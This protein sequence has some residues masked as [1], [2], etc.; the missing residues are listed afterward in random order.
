MGVEVDVR[1]AVKYPPEAFISAAP[2]DLVAGDNK[3]AEYAGFDPYIL[4]IQGLSFNRAD[5]LVFHLDAD[6]YTDV[7]RL[8][9]L[10]S[11][12]GLDFEEAVKVPVVR[13][14]TM[15]IT[16]PASMS[17]YQ[18]RHRVV[19]FRPTVA[20]KLQLGLKL[21]SEEEELA[22]RYGVEELLKLKTPEPFNLYSGV[23]ELREVAVKL[24]ASGAVARLVVPKGKKLVLLGVSAT[25]PPSPGS[26]Y[27]RVF[28]DDVEV[29]SLD[30]YCLPSLSYDAPVRVVALDRLVVEL[31]AKTPGDYYVRLVYGVGRLTV[32][33]K[34]MWGLALSPE[35]RALAEREGVFERVKVGVF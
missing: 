15:R 4:V 24:S 28:R 20:M 12:R 26:A 7:A 33:E 6:G 13:Y 16:S 23:E 31:D 30:L 34:V 11:A 21:T 29:M 2:V 1:R 22:E 5:G 3:V 18:F 35:E 10:G 27:L 9:N 17:A 25:R 8:D 14:A 19:V 32:T